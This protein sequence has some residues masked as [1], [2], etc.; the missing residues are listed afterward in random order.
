MFY[1]MGYYVYH[2]NAYNMIP[3]PKR[4]DNGQV[5]KGVTTATLQF[6]YQLH[7]TRWIMNL[8]YSHQTF[9]HVFP[10]FEFIEPHL[11]WERLSAPQNPPLTILGHCPFL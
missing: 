6:L 10:Q 3:V 2:R 11:F 7:K 4:L 9:K 5:Y 1:S 8:V